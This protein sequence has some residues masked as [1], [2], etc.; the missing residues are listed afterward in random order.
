MPP[1]KRDG[2]TGA[3]TVRTELEH[4]DVFDVVRGTF[5][6]SRSDFVALVMAKVCG[7]ETPLG[8]PAVPIDLEMLPGLAEAALKELHQEVTPQSAA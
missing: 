5:G 2:D 8:T 4:R 3:F 6:L 1:K 7:L